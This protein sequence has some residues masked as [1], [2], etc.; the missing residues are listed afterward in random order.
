MLILA[1]P[2]A[3]AVCLWANNLTSLCISDLTDQTWARSVPT[4]RGCCGNEMS[5]V[6]QMVRTVPGTYKALWHWL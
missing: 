2:L 5:S 3:K 6:G 4:P 1:L